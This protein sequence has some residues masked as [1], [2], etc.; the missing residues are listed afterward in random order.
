VN[1]WLWIPALLSILVIREVITGAAF[2]VRRQSVIHGGLRAFNPEVFVYREDN[3]VAFWVIIA[4][5]SLAV[6]FTW[7]RF[8][9]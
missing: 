9:T 7:W 1:A 2:F 3:P 8:W 6:A 4:L 5:H